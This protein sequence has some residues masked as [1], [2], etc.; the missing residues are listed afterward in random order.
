LNFPT[1][2]TTHP[3][4]DLP[5]AS[6]SILFVRGKPCAIEGHESV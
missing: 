4:N 6:H 3:W 1:H 5:M 2:Q